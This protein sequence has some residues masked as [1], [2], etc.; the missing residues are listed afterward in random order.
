MGLLHALAAAY[1]A[2]VPEETIFWGETVG[3]N[4]VGNVLRLY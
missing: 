2:A 3:P 4:D 1:L